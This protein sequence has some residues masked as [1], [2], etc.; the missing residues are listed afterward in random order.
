MKWLLQ[1]R[2]NA[3]KSYLESKRGFTKW[4][5][6]LEIPGNSFIRRNESHF[7]GE[8]ITL[9]ENGNLC[10]VSISDNSLWVSGEFHGI[11]RRKPGHDRLVFRQF[12]SNLFL[13][14]IILK[15]TSTSFNWLFALL[16]L[17][18]YLYSMLSIN[19]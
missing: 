12:I 14:L 13:V 17:R 4:P 16:S 7:F 19:Y 8:R 1:E 15:E 9:L 18:D 6:R 5:F 2:D 10:S 3:L 11:G